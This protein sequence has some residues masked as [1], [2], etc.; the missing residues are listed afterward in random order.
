MTFIL[1][2]GEPLL[3]FGVPL[4]LSQVSPSIQQRVNV[5]AT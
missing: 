1:Y 4:S 5:K 2:D 3:C